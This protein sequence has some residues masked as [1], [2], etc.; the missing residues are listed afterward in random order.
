[1]RVSGRK[2]LPESLLFTG[3]PFI[4]HGDRA[5]FGR[6]LDA[7]MRE[8]AGVRRLGSAALD[9]AYVA[10]GRCEGYWE[11]E[12]SIWDIAA[13]ILLVK[14][15]GGYVERPP[16]RPDHAA[17]G[18]G[19]RDQ[20]HPARPAPGPARQRLNP[21]VRRMPTRAGRWAGKPRPAPGP[22]MG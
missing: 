18:F 5:R 4:G 6:Q 12:I 2:Q 14:E 3:I 21:P 17:V 20:Q 8:T 16:G 11:E 7:A 1:M 13:G 9:L 22:P 15:A 19:A 10:A